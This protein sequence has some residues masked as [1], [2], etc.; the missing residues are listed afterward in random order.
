[1]WLLRVSRRAALTLALA[2]PVWAAAEA[3]RDALAAP[4]KEKDPKDKAR[5]LAKE[6][7]KVYDAGDPA[8]ALELFDEA[9]ALF[10][11][12]THTLYIARAQ[13]KLGKLVEAKASYQK[14]VAEDL[15]PKPIEIFTKAKESGKSELAALEP[16]I[17]RLG[18]EVIPGDATGLAVTMNNELLPDGKPSRT[19]EVNPGVYTFTARGN[20]LETK[21]EVVEAKEGAVIPVTL[22][23]PKPEVK[24]PPPPPKP[25]PLK[26]VGIATMALGGAGL[27]AGA[28]LGGLSFPARSDADDLFESCEADLGKGQCDGARADEVRAADNKATTFGNVGI[29]FLVGGGALVGT[30][31][32]LFVVGNK[33]KPADEQALVVPIIG[34]SFAGVRGSF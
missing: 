28:V 8:R 1:M 4:T 19:I 23:I 29:A 18:I 30:G 27:V 7:I 32:A 11:A 17:P 16:R 13:V 33:K 12:P 20:G 24:A 5:E 31:I 21:P 6:G 3:P 2:L 34:P 22:R 14:L 15:G 9:E 10:H 26:F 25:S